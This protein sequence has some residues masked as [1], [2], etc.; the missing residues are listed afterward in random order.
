MSSANFSQGSAK[1]H[2]RKRDAVTGTRVVRSLK[3]RRELGRI[4]YRGAM[5]GLGEHLPGDALSIAPLIREHPS[6]TP[7]GSAAADT[8]P[9][10]ARQGS[11]R[12]P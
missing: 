4:D 1:E 6:G 5:L 2:L 3:Q 11:H 12:R 7:V 9:V 8:S 10:D